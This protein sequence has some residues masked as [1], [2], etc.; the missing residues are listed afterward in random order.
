MQASLLLHFTDKNTDR[1]RL[2]NSPKALQLI[3]GGQSI[4]NEVQSPSKPVLFLGSS[5]KIV[6]RGEGHSLLYEK[7]AIDSTMCLEDAV[8]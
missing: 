8:L 5:W 4:Q 7:G 3:R 1:K 6:G 2:K